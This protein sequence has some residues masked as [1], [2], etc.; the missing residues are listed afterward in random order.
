M[1]ACMMAFSYNVILYLPFHARNSIA[2]PVVM[3]H[4]TY[5][6]HLHRVPVEVKRLGAG[7]KL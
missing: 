6:R 1:H 2:V 4:M 7:F 3:Y 5:E